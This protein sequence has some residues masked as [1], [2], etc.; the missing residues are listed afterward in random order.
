MILIKVPKRLRRLRRKRLDR[1]EQDNVSLPSYDEAIKEISTGESLADN[2]D[3]LPKFKDV[4]TEH[5]AATT[6]TS[7][8]E[9]SI[10]RQLEPVQVIP[11]HPNQATSDQVSSN[12]QVNADKASGSKK[13]INKSYDSPTHASSIRFKSDLSNTTRADRKPQQSR[14]VDRGHHLRIHYELILKNEDKVVK[15][16]TYFKAIQITIGISMIYWIT[17][18][19]IKGS[20][21]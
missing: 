10:Y 4:I 11:L 15:Q 3:I 21:L 20:F 16:Y 19:W 14:L 6:S 1:Y 8:N 18:E 9:K 17:I 5:Y 12:Q 13:C 2:Y 7:T